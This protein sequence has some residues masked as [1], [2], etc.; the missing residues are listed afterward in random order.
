ML[1]AAGE[2]GHVAYTGTPMA[3]APL[4]HDRYRVIRKL[5][6]G[7]FA[8]VYLAEDTR[9]GRSIAIKVVE[10]V[11]DCDGRA[12]REAQAAAKLDHPHIV[13]VHEVVSE[14]DRTLLFTEYVQ[15]HTLRE[16]YTRRRLTD[17]QLLRAG[18]Q[19]AG[20]LEHA[21]KRGVIHRDIKPEN[22]M[23]AESED[24]NVRVMDFGVA[25][26]EDLSSVTV[27]GDLVGT[28][29]YMAPE[30]LQGRQVDAKA[31]VYSLS[32]T[33]Y[34]G[35]TGRNPLRGKNP[36]ELLRGPS[37]MVFSRL[38]RLR[39][40]LPLVLDQALQLGLEKD[41]A[42]R[43]DAA[44]LRRMLERAAKEI[45][46]VEPTPSLGERA[47]AAIS[48]A[49]R[50]ERLAYAGEH[51]VAGAASLATLAYLLP[52]APFYPEV[53][54][55]PLAS[56]AAFLALLSPVS[57][58]AMTLALLAPPIFDFGLGWGI[59]YLIV[60]SVT[61]A[62]LRWRRKEWTALLP[63]AAPALVAAGVGLALPAAAGFLA[64]RWGPLVGGLA[65]I[66]IAVVGALGAWDTLPYA[67]SSLPPAGFSAA[68]HVISPGS[69]LVELARMFDR[70]PELLL[71]VG[72]FTVFAV[73]WG[74]AISGTVPRRL[75]MASLYLGL[76]FSLFVLGPPLLTGVGVDVRALLWSFWPCVIIVYT[77]ALLAPARGSTTAW[78]A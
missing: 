38:G 28:L 25:K 50:N 59:L 54:L 7:A 55:L 78:E 60:A 68:G 12:L 69:A 77:L 21:H 1:H 2:T 22:V 32:L 75:W 53:A 40:D 47:A 36:A 48:K 65:G 57:G 9:M 26:L 5:G 16:L 62:V 23:L 6:S 13:T 20:A 35:F 45:P 39:P 43:P 58:G 31:D 74:A 56:G 64:R 76:M 66:A 72:L 29:A 71:Q 52:R 67:F 11:D 8:T 61:F 27:D 41:P 4:L 14:A 44:E 42:K 15:G 46:E 70:S 33:L 37:R 30:Q 51:L 63:A 18:I 3:E 73:P 17:A 24:V 34:E 10:D 19:M 49:A